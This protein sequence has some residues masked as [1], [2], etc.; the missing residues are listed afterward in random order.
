MMS[1]MLAVEEFE[2][3]SSAR[4]IGRPIME[5]NTCAG[6]S[7]DESVPVNLGHLFRRGR[8]GMMSVGGPATGGLT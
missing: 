8:L 1:V 5:G 7:A 2:L 4:R 3:R 6:K